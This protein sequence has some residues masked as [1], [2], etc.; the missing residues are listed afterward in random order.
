MA[1][2]VRRNW[3][4]LTCETRHRQLRE[5]EQQQ[6]HA[7]ERKHRKLQHREQQH[8]EQQHEMQMG[9]QRVE[10]CGAPGTRHTDPDNNFEVFVGVRGDVFREF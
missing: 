8:C 6:S 4:Q 2:Q 10:P 1:T 9:G 5:E 7:P 3:D